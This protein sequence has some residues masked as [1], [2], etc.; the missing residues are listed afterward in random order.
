[1]AKDTTD[2]D[3]KYV[4]TGTM[5]QL[6]IGLVWLGTTMY[7]AHTTITGA[8]RASGS[9]G[10]AAASLPGVVA[11]TLVTAAP[12]GA[13][14]G[15]RRRGAV[16]RLLA[17]LALGTPVGLAAAAGIRLA[18]GGGA[19][20]TALAMTVGAAGIV[21]GALAVL[22]GAALKAGLWGT[23]WVFVAGVIFGVF[24]PKLVKLL[25]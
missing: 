6:C 2:T 4:A 3:T 23:T 14:A 9:L 11:A 24:Q 12:L 5:A 7:A 10:A 18:Y 17:G 21:G 19:D 20:I 16:R 1:M 22:P 8:E 15:P 13:A 25:G